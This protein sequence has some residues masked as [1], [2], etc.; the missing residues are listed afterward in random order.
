MSSMVGDSV[1][2]TGAGVCGQGK[3]RK[4]SM[5]SWFSTVQQGAVL[6]AVAG[7]CSLY[8]DHLVLFF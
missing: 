8:L 4:V 7:S 1:R 6:E 3:G 5:C 2:V